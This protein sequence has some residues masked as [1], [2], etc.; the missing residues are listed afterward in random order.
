MSTK[1]ALDLRFRVASGVSSCIRDLIPALL[2]AN[3]HYEFAIIKY[4]EQR[5]DF[6]DQI[7]HCIECPAKNDIQDIIWTNTTLR[8]LLK[9]GG[10][11][12]YHGMKW[13]GPMFNPV[14]SVFT[15][16]SISYSYRGEDFPLNLKTTLYLYLYH[17]WAVKRV[18][19][20]IAVSAFVRDFLNDCFRISGNRIKQI[21]NGVNPNCREFSAL[22]K[23]DNPATQRYGKNY[24]LC[25]GNL[26]ERK[27]QRLAI[28]ALYQLKDECDYHLVCAGG[29]PEGY[30]EILE[31]E[32]KKLGIAERVHFAGFTQG[33]ELLQ[34]FNGARALIHA[35]FTEGLALAMVEAAK[36]GLPIVT[37]K[38]QGPMEVFSDA[39][40]F[41]DSPEDINGLANAIRQL[42]NDD[43]HYE[44]CRN[45]C[46]NIAA[47]FCW[48]SAAYQYLAIYDVITGLDS[49]PEKKVSIDIELEDQPLPGSA[50][51]IKKIAS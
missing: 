25:V 6:E 3:R 2:E 37:T 50:I 36:C 14:K 13:A 10:Y 11:E 35:S 47:Q 27:N 45:R 22:E 46:Q 33:D 31:K 20:I 21:Y 19:R 9:D 15:A 12:I 48:N 17:I 39:A 29:D 26:L 8:R 49:N 41:I 28:Q 18:D 42:I 34:L 51:D 44:E 43:T 24:L 30:Q 32:A 1:I 40:V 4:P 23:A 5:F 38:C 7:A 16:H